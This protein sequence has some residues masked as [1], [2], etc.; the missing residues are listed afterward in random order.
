MVMRPSGGGP[1]RVWPVRFRL[2]RFLETS[3]ARLSSS[4]LCSWF[5]PAPFGK[6]NSWLRW[7]LHRT[8]LGRMICKLF[9]TH[10]DRQ[11]DYKNDYGGHSGTQALRPWTST[12]WMGN[13]L[14]IHNYETDWFQLARRGNIQVHIADVDSLNERTALLSD[15]TQIDADMVIC[16]TGW[17]AEPSIKFL[18]EG[19]A[20]QLGLPSSNRT[21]PD[22]ET[23][24]DLA[25]S[26]PGAE[27]SLGTDSFAAPQTYSNN[28][29]PVASRFNGRTSHAP[30]RPCGPIVYI[31]SWSLWSKDF[32]RT[33]ALR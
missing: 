33:G 17:R 4:R 18:P 22:P 7:L 2:F 3:I 10:L 14:S 5:D 20:S 19:L 29:C 9:W 6:S 12:Y 25:L 21:F 27:G 16:C 32:S 28:P 30:V 13:S 26:G 31:A 1:S 23:K 11:V 8:S 15:G 24:E